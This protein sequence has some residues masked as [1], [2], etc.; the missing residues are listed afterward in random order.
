M[1]LTRFL[2]SFLLLMPFLFLQSV[3]AA[4]VDTYDDTPEVVARVSRISFMT[5][6]VQIRRSGSDEWERAAL[7]LPLVEGD[8]IATGADARVELQ[9]DTYNYVRLAENSFLTF[10]TLRDNQVA[11][12]LP[13]GMMSIRVLSFDTAQN[14]F[15]IDVPKTTLAVQKAGMYRIDAGDKASTSINLSVTDGGQARIYSE[16]SGFLL[17][18]GRTARLDL[19]G[20]NVGE[21]EIESV[22]KYTD[23]WDS[24]VLERDAIVAKKLKDSYYDKYYDRDIYGAED[25]NEYGDWIY[26]RSYGYVWRPYSTATSTY[27][28]WTPYR[29]GSWRWMPTYGWIWMG[30]E[31]WGWSTYHYGRWVFYGGV[32]VWTPYAEH[33]WGRSWWQPA[34][35]VISLY[36]DSVCWYPLPYNYYYYNYNSSYYDS[37]YYGGYYGGHHGGGHHNGGG[38]NGGGNGG[39]NG[40]NGGNGGAGS[41][42]PT[43]GG[44]PNVLGPGLVKGPKAPPLQPAGPLDPAY[45]QAVS[46]VGAGGFGSGGRGLIKQAPLSIATKA[47]TRQNSPEPV[48]LPAATD[49]KNTDVKPNQQVQAVIR[50]GK[51]R[52]GGGG[53]TGNGSITTG[54]AVREPGVKLDENL[55]KEKVLG[56]RPPVNTHITG[57]VGNGAASGSAGTEVKE[58]GVRATGAVKRDDAPLI[59][60][61]GGQPGDNSEPVRT[62]SVK[63]R[64]DSGS[65]NNDSEPVQST[66]KPRYEP[67]PQQEK[68]RNDP[69]P[70]QEKPRNDP[71]PRQEKPR[72]DPPPRN[73]PPPRSEPRSEPKSEPRSEP[74]SQP[75]SEPKSEP[76]SEPSRSSDSKKK[77]GR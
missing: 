12:S 21:P 24:W 76:K 59:K 33:R 38:N 52:A 73:D 6:E 18:N 71:P 31:P 44:P 4:N 74:R 67:P 34:F 72:Y 9:L 15:E 7:N 10:N 1:R 48:K 43:P 40:G 19:D 20:D 64:N 45:T 63:P 68:P 56:G 11:L 17:K 16:N 37:G 5:G 51:V 41:P 42:T 22:A 65:N 69:P 3:L 62:P 61:A 23:E 57:G 25:L 28:N 53:D 66:P 70:Q 8:Q 35:V 75:R 26:T 60:N 50:N 46:T 49:V 27:S 54:A 47:I 2:G 13:E 29:Y 58:S 39:G 32:W 14:S 36:G 55:R 77:D 30:D